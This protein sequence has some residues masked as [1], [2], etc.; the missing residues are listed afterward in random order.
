MTTTQRLLLLAIANAVSI[1]SLTYF[2]LIDWRGV[3]VP[4]A[5][6]LILNVLAIRR[7]TLHQTSSVDKVGHES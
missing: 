2:A 3:V 5:F 6:M 7:I 1:A 4:T